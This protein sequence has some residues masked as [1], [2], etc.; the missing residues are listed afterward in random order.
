MFP[1]GTKVKT[2]YKAGSG[3]MSNELGDN[4]EAAFKVSMKA[5]SGDL[6]IKS[7]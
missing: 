7:Y 4:P 1:K 5:G 2:S 6:K 3:E